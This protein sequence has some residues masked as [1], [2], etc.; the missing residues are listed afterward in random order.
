MSAPSPSFSRDFQQI[1]SCHHGWLQNWLRRRLGH[2]GDA[3]DIA[4]DTFERLLRLGS[5]V[6][7][8]EPRAYLCT[9]AGR[10]AINHQRRQQIETLCIETLALTG[11]AQAMS[12][13]QRHLLHE[14]LCRL[15]ALLDRLKPK[16]RQV[17]LLSQLEDLTYREIAAE[18]GISDR[19]VKKYMAQ[20]MFHCLKA[21]LWADARQII[22]E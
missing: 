9:L 1:Y 19:M 3:A 10:L 5:L 12:V 2:G 16:A 18:M 14:V 8:R 22:S 6:G 17:F 15:D 4:Q 11:D 13:E 21:D 7:I 20:A